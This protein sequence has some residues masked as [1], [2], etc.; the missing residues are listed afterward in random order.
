MHDGAEPESR[1]G[2]LWVVAMWYRIERFTTELSRAIDRLDSQQWLAI[3]VA[4]IVLGAIFLRGY[5]SRTNY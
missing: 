1:Q 4:A 2:P 5:G 3:S